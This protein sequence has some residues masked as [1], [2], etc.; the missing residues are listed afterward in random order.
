[1]KP[2]DLGSFPVLVA[3]VAERLSISPEAAET[4]LRAVG[5][6]LVREVLTRR[7]PVRWPGLGLFQPYEQASRMVSLSALK[8]LGHVP[9]TT[10]D[11][12][13]LPP[14]RKLRFRPS[15]YSALWR[16]AA[17]EPEEGETP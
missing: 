4:V 10:P 5:D 3:L 8:Q 13:E 14:Q 16:G 7:N 6:A 15:R 1:M 12:I 2:S 9:E 11:T 17:A